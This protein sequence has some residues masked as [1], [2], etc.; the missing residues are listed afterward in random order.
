MQ[1][2]WNSFTWAAPDTVSSKPISFKQRSVQMIF[3]VKQP[4]KK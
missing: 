4:K 1:Q 3:P 2:V